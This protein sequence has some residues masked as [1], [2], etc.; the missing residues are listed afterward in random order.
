MEKEGAP[1]SQGDRTHHS[2]HKNS[3]HLN[4]DIDKDTKAEPTLQPSNYSSY[5]FPG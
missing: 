3:I 1:K 5:Q 2:E 4:T